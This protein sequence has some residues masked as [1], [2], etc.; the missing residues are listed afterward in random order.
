MHTPKANTVPAAA[1]SRGGWA[2]EALLV[3]GLLLPLAACD[4][5]K[6]LTVEERD[7]VTPG[8]LT[9]KS[10]LPALLAGAQAEFQG[11]YIGNSGPAAGGG[12][13]G[14]S[15]ITLSGLMTDEL[16][17]I[18]TFPTRVEVDQRL[19]QNT[20]TTMLPVYRALQLARGSA[21][22][23]AAAY[24][25][26][27]STNVGRA[28][29]LGLSGMAFVLF[30]ENYCSGV[31]VSRQNEAGELEFGDPI[32]TQAQ[33]DSA[34]VRFDQA[35]TIA[36]AAGATGATRL[37]LARVGKG[38][39]LLNQGKFAEAAAAVTA[40][41]TTFAYQVFGSENSPRENN[42]VYVLGGPPSRRYAGGPS[43]KA[44]PNGLNFI[45]ADPRAVSIRPT[46]TTNGFDNFNPAFYQQK[47]PN[48]SAPAVLA[49]GVEA[50]LIEAEAALQAGDL[51]TFLARLNAARAQRGPATLPQLTAANLPATR[52][53]QVT[54]LFTERAYNQ[55]L[56]SHRLG[57]FRRLIRQYGR[58]SEAVFPSG[59][60]YPTL[61]PQKGGGRYFTDVNFP[62]PFEEQ[63]NPQFTDC[64]DRKA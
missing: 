41:P 33:F 19:I 10:A 42:G 1:R 17:N 52:E 18:E 14:D 37:N 60:N 57:D 28:E 47:Y 34:I 24:A 16:F 26:L 51:T 36:T 50:R 32:P 54:L 2:L 20:N 4:I 15:Q 22:R 7:V 3:G 64:L 5:D 46:P 21:D 9:D 55:W 30:G 11:A 62:I 53:G 43:T 58:D 23:A 35:I 49:D 13:G 61:G 38:R 40:V 63:N 8:Q 12:T 31:P 39:A 56:T 59:P 27:D 25:K 45:D 29:V 48:R 6:A 44:E